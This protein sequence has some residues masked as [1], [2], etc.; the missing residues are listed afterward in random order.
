VRI[1]HVIV[2]AA[3]LDAAAARLEADHGLRASGGWAVA[4]DDVV[5]VAERLGTPVRTI[6]RQGLSAQLAG[7]LKAMATPFLPFFI[8]RD[9]GIEDPGASGG[10][11]GI[12][13][14]EVAGDPDRLDAWLGG[15]RLQVRVVE[16]PPAV[17][18]VAISG[19]ILR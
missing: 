9:P 2:A 19:R 13:W 6:V 17:R 18:A 15:A 8:A 12:E 7:V 1:D 16:G 10:A 5:P 11:G 14:I 3:D 4:V